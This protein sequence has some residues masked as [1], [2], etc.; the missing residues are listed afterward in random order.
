MKILFTKR[1]LLRSQQK[2][3]FYDILKHNILTRAK[4][5]IR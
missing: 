2:F 1:D 5:I 4:I 3:P